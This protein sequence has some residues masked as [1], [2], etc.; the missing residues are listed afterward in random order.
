M[1]YSNFIKTLTGV[2]R[3]Y[4]AGMT[5]GYPACCIEHFVQKV[6]IERAEDPWIDLDGQWFFGSGYIA[7]PNCRQLDQAEILAG[8]EQRRF[9]RDPFPTERPGMLDIHKAYRHFKKHGSPEGYGSLWTLIEDGL[10]DSRR[11]H[12]KRVKYFRDE[13]SSQHLACPVVVGE[14]L[15]KHRKELA[16]TNITFDNGWSFVPTR[17]CGKPEGLVL[18]LGHSRGRYIWAVSPGSKIE[19]K[20]SDSLVRGFV[21]SR[22]HYTPETLVTVPVLVRELYDTIWNN[23]ERFYDYGEVNEYLGRVLFRT[24]DLNYDFKV[25]LSGWYDKHGGP[26]TLRQMV[27]KIFEHQYVFF[28]EE[29]DL[30]GSEPAPFEINFY[31][32][33]YG[34]GDLM[35]FRQFSKANEMLP[36]E[37]KIKF[38]FAAVQAVRF[39]SVVSKTIEDAIKFA[40]GEETLMT[41]GLKQFVGEDLMNKFIMAGDYTVVSYEERCVYF[42]DDTFQR[43]LWREFLTVLNQFLWGL[44]FGTIPNLS[45][46]LVNKLGSFNQRFEINVEELVEKELG[47]SS[48]NIE[49]MKDAIM[50]A[51]VNVI[52]PVDPKVGRALTDEEHMAYYKRIAEKTPEGYQLDKIISAKDL[53]PHPVRFDDPFQATDEGYAL[54]ANAHVFPIDDLNL[55]NPVQIELQN[56]EEVVP[57]HFEQLVGRLNRKGSGEVRVYR[58]ERRLKDPT[59]GEA[60]EIESEVFTK[61]VNKGFGDELMAQVRERNENLQAPTEANERGLLKIISEQGDKALVQ[62]TNFELYQQAGVTG[63]E[64][65]H[66]DANPPT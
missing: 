35:K 12:L 21:S 45:E 17:T 36:M 22:G 24:P 49:S 8:I 38:Y 26:E 3:L 14:F 65:K 66:D 23:D 46:P 41:I 19:D 13:R 9:A 60:H 32:E 61:P 4:L 58:A 48:Q 10:A 31:H 43:G 29:F 2:N 28:D 52:Q 47:D 11:K 30:A 42:K 6:N 15:R 40:K 62:K 59:V 33:Q 63:S 20:V 5:Y 53:S 25:Q 34:W 57:K 39:E 51:V 37:L 27:R 64:P 18:L 56:T 50:R 7:C 44:P 54:E 1:L 16:K 55:M